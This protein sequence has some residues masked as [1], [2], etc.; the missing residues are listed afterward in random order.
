MESGIPQLVAE[1][2]AEF[3]RVHSKPVNFF[4]NSMLLS[5]LQEPL[6]NIA[7]HNVTCMNEGIWNRLPYQPTLSDLAKINVYSRVLSRYVRILEPVWFELG[8]APREF[9]R[10][11]SGLCLPVYNRRK[12]LH[13]Q[14][15]LGVSCTILPQREVEKIDPERGIEVGTALAGWSGYV[16]CSTIELNCLLCLSV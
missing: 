9:V 12:G 13:H 7:E 5:H 11:G 2:N 16:D 6:A 14:E 15:I 3:A 8:S 10:N 1:L 4:V